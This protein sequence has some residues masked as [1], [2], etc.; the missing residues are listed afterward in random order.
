VKTLR[1]AGGRL[2]IPKP[3]FLP[4]KPDGEKKMP[5]MDTAT[6]QTSPNTES[7][8]VFFPCYNEQD[9]VRRVYQSAVVVLENIGVNYQLI[10]VDDGSRDRTAKVVDDIAAADPRVSVVHHPTNLGYGA[11][12]Q[13]GFRAATKK[14]VFYTDGDG[15][16]DL[17]ELP[18]LI[19][20]MKHYDIVSCFRL[21]RRENL[22]RKFN[23]W[24]WTRFVCFL[25]H[26][27]LKD[28]NCAF[29]LFKREVF[30]NLE[31]RSTGA[32]INTEILARAIRRGYT[33]TQV[34]VHHLPRTSGRSTGSRPD[35]IFRAF[36][37]LV[38]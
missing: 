7:L 3:L 20:L 16:F 13:S 26:L 25:F 10:F 15:Q 32:L 12:L 28:I 2:S 14:L 8:S 5:M 34:G 29:K 21:D 22:I 6:T 35:V 11:A 1:N 37:E 17:N 23:A 30:D 38:K 27:R 9:N 31:L 36:R 18:A 4:N 24:C 33:I 19:P